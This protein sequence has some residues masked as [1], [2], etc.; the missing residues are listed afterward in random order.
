[1]Y[2]CICT[3]E[4]KQVKGKG[5]GARSRD[6]THDE[7]GMW[8]GGGE[9]CLRRK[10]QR[11]TQPAAVSFAGKYLNEWN[12]REGVREET[13]NGTRANKPVSER[14]KKNTKNERKRKEKGIHEP[15]YEVVRRGGRGDEGRAGVADSTVEEELSETTGTTEQ[16]HKSAWIKKRKQRDVG[17]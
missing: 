2:V 16:E 10:G 17:S 13:L 1:M 7:P 5:E 14:N 11:A 3:R 9:S 12:Q 6:T 15:A 4:R 8:E